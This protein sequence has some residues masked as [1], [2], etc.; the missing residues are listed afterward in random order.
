M[1]AVIQR[2]DSA[3]VTIDGKI[4]SEINNG[5]LVLLGIHKTDKEEDTL[6]LAKKIIDL[7]IF[8]DADDKMNLNV[9]DIDGEIL[10]ISQFTLCT[11]NGKSGNRPSFFKA[12]LPERANKLYKLFIREMKLYYDNTKIKSGVFG[13]MM[14]VNLTND[15]PVTIILQRN[16]E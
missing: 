1:T 2:V 7:R 12:E 15:G 13:A 10:V 5:L 4:F 9:K 8:N 11:D 3:K 6:H 16:Q 14:K